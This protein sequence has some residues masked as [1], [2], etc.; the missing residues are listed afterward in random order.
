MLSTPQ[1]LNLYAVPVQ[2]I[3]APMTPY[4]TEQPSFPQ[5]YQQYQQLQ[6]PSLVNDSLFLQSL[7]SFVPNTHFTS[8]EY[9]QQSAQYKQDA[10][11]QNIAADTTS[12][13]WPNM[14]PLFLES[15]KPT[16]TAP[17][18]A[19]PPGELYGTR[20]KYIHSVAATGKVVFR[21][22]E[23]APQYSGI[24]E[25]SNFGIIRMSTALKS[26]NSDAMVPALAL[27]FLRDG[28]DSANMMA[29]ISIAGQPGEWNYFA[30]DF[31]NHI[32]WP[33]S[34]LPI[35]ALSKKFSQETDMIQ[36][37]GLSNMAQ[38]DEAGNYVS[39]PSF[40]WKLRFQPH[41]DVHNII[42][43]SQQANM[44]DGFA[45]QLS[46][47]VPQNANLYQVYAMDKPEH[48]GGT[49]S[50]IGV[51]QLNG[52]LTTSKWADENLFFRHQLMNDDIKMVPSWAQYMPL[53]SLSGKCPAGFQS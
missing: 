1:T 50:L 23:G 31:S 49:E 12:G 8:Q 24:F 33:G 4:S 20:T 42:P 19:M 44:G 45:Q 29:M 6:Q 43:D 35:L 7:S 9:I 52:G 27:K 39:N 28:V 46:A 15:L 36:A 32:P 25:G 21:R 5:Q 40:P 47:R 53:F 14:A 30:N 22:Y 18:D 41:Q 10:L 17:G 26:S 3:Q 16:F 13:D 2:F 48:A 34:S 38:F 37:V 11:W 51:L